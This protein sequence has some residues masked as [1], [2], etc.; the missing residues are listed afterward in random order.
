[1]DVAYPKTQSFYFFIDIDTKEMW[2][3]VQG[4]SLWVWPKMA[5][6]M[7]KSFQFYFQQSSTQL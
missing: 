4:V 5:A 6:D 1:M 3:N 7:S 2:E